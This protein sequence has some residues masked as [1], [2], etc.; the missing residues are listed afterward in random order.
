MHE[1]I[2]S[3][4]I[5][6]HF[7][8]IED[9]RIERNK[10]HLL[11]D[12]ITITIVAVLCGAEGWEDVELYGRLKEGWLCRFLELPNGIPSHDTLRRVF[13]RLNPEQLYGCFMSWVA[14]V[15]QQVDGELVA[16]DGKTVR[17]SY[18]SS[19]GQGPLHLVSAWSHQNGLVLGQFE[20]AEASNEITAIPGLVQLLDLKGCIVTIDA[21]GCQSEIARLLRKDKKADYVL[22]VKANQPTLLKEIE[23]FFA[24][25]DPVAD[26]QQGL[27]DHHHTVDK[28]HGRLEI[29]DYYIS[30]EIDWLAEPLRAFTDAKSIG[31]VCSRRIVNGKESFQR[32]YYLTSLRGDAEQFARAV[33]SHWGIENSLHWSLD[34]TF[35]EDDSRIRT[36][37][38]PENLA[39]LRKIA[40]TLVRRDSTSKHSLRRRRKQAAWDNDYLERLLFATDEALS[41]RAPNAV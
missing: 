28:D 18:D 39:V 9:P 38:S 5:I 17:R 11:L 4:R 10:R 8:Q 16:I 26:V 23:W 3:K 41:P 15:R 20:T 22:A 25:L 35:R 37:D 14:A 6:D 1:R 19:R 33:R 13:V 40:L 7:R 30:E 34:T 29:R 12:I 27:A 21:I 2:T 31:M 36:G 24:D 32:R